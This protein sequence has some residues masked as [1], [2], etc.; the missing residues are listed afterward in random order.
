MVE[1]YHEVIMAFVEVGTLLIW[2]AFAQLFFLTMKRQRRV[3]FI[4]HAEG[5]DCSSMKI[6]FTNMAAEPVYVRNIFFCIECDDNSNEIYNLDDLHGEKLFKKEIEGRNKWEYQ[7]TIMPG[8]CVKVEV[9]GVFS[10][11]LS[12]RDKKPQRDTIHIVPGD[13]VNIFVVFFHGADQRLV[14]ASRHF[15]FFQ[16]ASGDFFKAL[17]W[18]TTSWAT[19]HER[20]KLL[21]ALKQDKK[22]YPGFY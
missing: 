1:D 11:C 9:G 10:P 17:N 20:K 18:N 8:T 5:S 19:G 2:I 4:I 21:S 3:R 6:V 22:D 7:G 15:K 12:K 14:G 13:I 16:S